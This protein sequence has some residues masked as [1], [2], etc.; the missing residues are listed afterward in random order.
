MTA[1]LDSAPVST[2]LED[3]I[4]HI[5]AEDLIWVRVAATKSVQTGQWQQTMLDIVSG[6][7]PPA[8]EEL[9]WEYPLAIF[10]AREQRGATL[11]SWLHDGRIGLDHIAIELPD[12][13]QPLQWER[14]RTLSTYSSY[15]PLPWPTTTVM[16]SPSAKGQDFGSRDLV[17]NTEGTPS[18]AHYYA[19]ASYVFG[20][21]KS[22]AGGRGTAAP[23][24][25][26]QDTRARINMITVHEFGDVLPIDI[27]GSS[28]G[29]CVIELS[30][31]VPGLSEKLSEQLR[32]RTELKIPNGL[33]G[34]PWVLIRS[35]GNW[36][37]R[38]TLL[39]QPYGRETEP[40][41]VFVPEAKT[42]LD[43]L[44]AAHENPEAEF[45]RELPERQSDDEMLRVMKTVAAFANQTGGVLLVGVDK[46]EQVYGVP[47]SS[48]DAITDRLTSLVGDWVHPRPEFGFEEHS[49]QLG[50]D[51]IVI[52][53]RVESGQ[54]VPYTAGKVSNRDRKAYIRPFSQSIPAN[55]RDIKGI[56]LSRVHVEP[57]GPL[58]KLYNRS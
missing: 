35:E 38:R 52:G 17:S 32:Q 23:M 46:D 57:V 27:E 44:I 39:E 10:I 5:E 26:H 41:V 47:K 3:V 12:I 8:F 58:A 40:G 34:E 54:D 50:E 19:A 31:N 2:S 43:A 37:D 51:V 7:M 56:V 16:F 48:F 25:R 6:E 22:I 45:K 24:Y 4:A 21:G 28:L 11:A 42:P 29:E 13:A 9:K 49:T 33:P 20:G 36:L 18:F 15:Q 30:G 14:H 1:P 55:P 53:L